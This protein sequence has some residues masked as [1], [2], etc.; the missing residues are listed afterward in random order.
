M[1]KAKT[2]IPQYD[3][4]ANGYKP[5]GTRAKDANGKTIVTG[6]EE[7]FC[8][9]CV[10]YYKRL[11]DEGLYPKGKWSMPCKGDVSWKVQKYQDIDPAELGMTEEEFDYFLV[12]LDPVRWAEYEFSMSLDW[13]Q[14]E[15]ARCTALWKTIRG[16]RR[17][18]KT[19]TGSIDILYSCYTKWGMQIPRYE[20]LV[21]CPYEAQ[22]KK[23]FD[24]LEMLVSLSTNLKAAVK[25]VRKSPHWEMEFHNGS[26]ARGFSSGKKTGARSDK[27]R[28]QDAHAI[29]FDEIDYMADEDIEA[30]FAVL[31]SQENVRLWMSTTPTGAR[32]KFWRVSTDKTQGFKEFHFIS[33][34]S[35]R[36]TPQA[37]R[38]FKA[39]YSQ[40]GYD[41]EFNAEFGTPTEGVFRQADLD[42]CL[43]DYDYEDCS[44]NSDR[45]YVI[46]VD[47]NK[48]TG[49]HIVVVEGDYKD[50]SHARFAVV[51]KRIIRPQ[52]FTQ[53]AGVEAVLELDRQ[54]GADFVYVDAGYGAVQVEMLHRLDKQH[55]MAGMRYAERVVSVNMAEKVEFRDPRNPGRW[56]KKAAKP[57]MV[58]M[59]A[60]W[61]SSQQIVFPAVEDTDVSI[62]ESE[63]AYLDIGLIQQM[64]EFKVEKVSPTGQVRYSQGYEH[65]LVAL[66]LA[67]MGHALQ[68]SELNQN[69]VHESIRYTDISFG[70]KRDE[71]T[72]SVLEEE[73]RKKVDR[74]RRV[75]EETKPGRNVLE[76][77]ASGRQDLFFGPLRPVK[78]KGGFYNPVSPPTRRIP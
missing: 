70:T 18:G 34:E 33:N 1:S 78:R 12:S 30:I 21:I 59:L 73:R 75:R 25:A 20:Y 77:P 29:L 67:C 71:N 52:E 14:A 57:F 9:R 69:I 45:K 48:L 32:S 50:R 35:P 42:A 22:V 74:T 7:H 51:D 36:W 40:G 39:M 46:G 24:N 68:F 26:I 4:K 27:I 47:W 5:M 49:T 61:V 53:M 58:D 56:I 31:G 13:Y 41:R 66:A 44:H 23:I 55:P 62:I 19:F 28:G 10:N 63:I 72:M 11:A 76:K 8:S 43:R 16:G 65:T 3:Y 37:E 6:P 64:R 38:F 60:G 17:I 15:I 2:Y 54:W